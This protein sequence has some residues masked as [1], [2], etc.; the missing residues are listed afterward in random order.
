MGREACQAK[1]E[2]GAKRVYAIKCQMRMADVDWRL[3]PRSRTPSTSGDPKG[4]EATEELWHLSEAA[5]WELSHGGTS[6][7]SN[8]VLAVLAVSAVKCIGTFGPGGGRSTVDLPPLWKLYVSDPSHTRQARLYCRRY[9]R[10][11]VIDIWPL[12][13]HFALM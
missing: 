8:A 12:L 1:K 10:G 11:M 5:A 9:A 6:S 13:W 4:G 3:C 7:S 2:G